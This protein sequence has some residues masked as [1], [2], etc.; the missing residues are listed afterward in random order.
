[1]KHSFEVISRSLVHP[2]YTQINFNTYLPK[3]RTVISA[4][5]FVEYRGLNLHI[6]FTEELKCTKDFF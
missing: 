3:V 1:M 4:A 2:D 6:F 5:K